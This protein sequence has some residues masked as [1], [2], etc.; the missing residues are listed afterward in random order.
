[1]DFN[2]IKDSKPLDDI[3][4]SFYS[5]IEK[6]RKNEVNEKNEKNEINDE[7]NDG[8]NKDALNKFL[9]KKLNIFQ[10]NLKNHFDQM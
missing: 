7:W 4:L 1:M 8:W 9:E 6:N 10:N 5:L 3:L 2:K